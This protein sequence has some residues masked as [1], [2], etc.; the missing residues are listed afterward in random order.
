MRVHLSPEHGSS[1]TTNYADI[2]FIGATVT[3]YP[4]STNSTEAFTTCKNRHTVSGDRVDG[5]G[6]HYAG[7]MVVTRV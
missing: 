6:G 3:W 2:T 4:H 7:M 1:Y 5:G